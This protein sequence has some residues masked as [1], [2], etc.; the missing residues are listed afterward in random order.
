M[1]FVQP[2]FIFVSIDEEFFDLIDIANNIY[3]TDFRRLKEDI[4]INSDSD[5]IELHGNVGRKA[6]TTVS[7]LKKTFDE[8]IFKIIK[9]LCEPPLSLDLNISDTEKVLLIDQLVFDILFDKYLNE[10]ELMTRN[11]YSTYMGNKLYSDISQRKA[12][13]HAINECLTRGMK[14]NHERMSRTGPQ[15]QIKML[16]ADPNKYAKFC[17]PHMRENSH[18]KKPKF[19][20]EQLYFNSGLD[21]TGRQYRRQLTKENRD[22]PYER[23][24]HDLNS[25]NDFVAKLLPAENESYENY[26]RMSMDYYVL[27]SYK[28]VDFMF[29]LIVKNF[30]RK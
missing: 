1:C 28:R 16:G 19:V 10:S 25:Y 23:I 5:P 30:W 14:T 15:E 4:I 12:A 8:V 13:S 21:L 17:T 26:F 20:W 11:S 6:V 9:Y 27:E 18:S 22:Y 7:Q 3:F 29:K 24:V 2:D